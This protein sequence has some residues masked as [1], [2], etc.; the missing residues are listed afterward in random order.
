[1]VTKEVYIGFYFEVKPNNPKIIKTKDVYG[2]E[3]CK[4]SELSSCLFCPT[5]GNKLNKYQ[6]KDEVDFSLGDILGEEFEDDIIFVE[7]ECS[8]N[9]WIPN[10]DHGIFV[11]DKI[12][13]LKDVIELNSI[14]D[15]TEKYKELIN[16]IE[17]YV[18][19]KFGIIPYYN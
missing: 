6:K 5:C 11:G 18:F 1:M 12:F 19:I 3:K 13:S 7:T 14:S 10:Y 15:F 17:P 8:S 2:C 4:S 9:I 16:K